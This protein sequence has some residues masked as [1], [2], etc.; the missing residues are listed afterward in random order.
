MSKMIGADHAAHANPTGLKAGYKVNVIPQTGDRRSLTG[1]SCPATRK[2]SSPRST[3]CSA[4]RSSREFIHHDIAL[5]TTADGDL[6]DAMSASLLRGRSA[7]RTWRP[8][9]C[10]REPTRSGS[11]KLGIRCFGFSPLRL[12]A[13]TGFLRHVPR[14]RRAGAGR[15]PARSACACWTGSSTCLNGPGTASERPYG[16]YDATAEGSLPAAVGEQPEPGQ[17]PATVLR[18]VREDPPRGVAGRAAWQVQDEV[19]V[20][21]H[22]LLLCVRGRAAQAV[23]GNSGD[24]GGRPVNSGREQSGRLQ[25]VAGITER[26]GTG[27]SWPRRVWYLR[28]AS[29]RNAAEAAVCDGPWRGCEVGKSVPARS[30]AAGKTAAASD[31]GDNGAAPAA[32]TRRQRERP[33]HQAGDRRV[34]CQG[35]DHR[36]LPRQGI[37]GRIEHRPHSRHA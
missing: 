13:G 33:R 10:P 37:R 15:R 16:A 20:L 36:R 9:A 2:S 19:V 1:A 7:R 24:C 21:G 32:A 12:P 28:R 35:P 11:A 17:F 6:W 8:T 18:V 30:K 14:H 23:L 3:G 31:N 5:E 25:R 27:I 34:P 26:A 22:C 29:R 4:P